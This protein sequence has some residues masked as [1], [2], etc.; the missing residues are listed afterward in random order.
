MAMTLCAECAKPISTTA[1][2]CPHCGA[3][4]EIALERTQKDEPM[5]ELLESAV[6]TTSMWPEG[7]VRA[8]QWA[9]VEQVKLDE[10]EVLDWDELFR[11]LERL[12]RLKML[13]LSQT[14]FNTLNL[15]QGLTTLRYLYLEKNGITDLMPLVALPELKQV[16][17]YGNPIV[18][19]EVT[20]LEAAMP[21]CSVFV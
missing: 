8:E 9:A 14:G 13:G 21:Q 15:L 16:W 18:P 2:M 17:L 20:R 10:V 1:M 4:A 7:E 6:R 11:G 19:E 12:P 5:P 3:P